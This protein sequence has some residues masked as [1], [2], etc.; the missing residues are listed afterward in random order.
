MG[1]DLGRKRGTVPPKFDSPCLR[2][3][4]FRRNTLYHKKCPY[5][6]LLK[7]HFRQSTFHQ[8][9]DEMT[10]KKVIKNFGWKNRSLG[11]KKVIQKFG[12]YNKK[13]L[14]TNIFGPPNPGPSSP[15]MEMVRKIK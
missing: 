14:D 13:I 7:L 1:G 3:P 2:P 5:P 6:I 9:I 12:S 10:T 8:S 11:L 4:I 15:P